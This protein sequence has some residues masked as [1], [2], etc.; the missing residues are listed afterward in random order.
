MSLFSIS[1]TQA[2]QEPEVETDIEAMEKF[3]FLACSP[4]FA[5]LAFLFNP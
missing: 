2:E 5:Q 4:W 3:C 1:G